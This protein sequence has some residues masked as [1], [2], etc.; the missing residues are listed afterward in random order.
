MVG[1]YFLSVVHQRNGGE[2]EILAASDPL[3]FATPAAHICCTAKAGV[4]VWRRVHGGMLRC[5]QRAR[6]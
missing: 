6:R 4:V 2:K 5:K 1:V 3:H